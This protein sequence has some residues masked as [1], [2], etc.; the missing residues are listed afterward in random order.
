[1]ASMSAGSRLREPTECS[2][3]DVTMNPV[4]RYPLIVGQ[5]GRAFIPGIRSYVLAWWPLVGRIVLGRRYLG[6]DAALAACRSQEP[7]ER[8]SPVIEQAGR[9][10]LAVWQLLGCRMHAG[11]LSLRSRVLVG[12]LFIKPELFIHFRSYG[13]LSHSPRAFS[14][15]SNSSVVTLLN[16]DS[17]SL[18]RDLLLISTASLTLFAS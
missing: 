13:L 4:E 14:L 12:W 8:E 2:L 11:R 10:L 16:E 9:A 6:V 3:G 15:V 5:D 17:K 7:V 1:M 18:N